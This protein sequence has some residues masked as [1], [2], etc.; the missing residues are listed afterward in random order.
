ML[1]DPASLHMFMRMFD[2]V[3]RID[4]AGKQ[5]LALALPESAPLAEAAVKALTVTVVG[6][7]TVGIGYLALSFVERHMKC[8]EQLLEDEKKCADAYPD[9]P[10]AKACCDQLARMKVNNC[11]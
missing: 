3:N 2:P 10:I 8:F 6:V 1:L 4:P 11:A 9:D 7:G 5:A